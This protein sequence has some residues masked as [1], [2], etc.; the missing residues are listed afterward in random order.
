M[1]PFPVELVI[2][3]AWAAVALTV[4]F[5]IGAILGYILSPEYEEQKPG[6]NGLLFLLGCVLSFAALYFSFA[7]KLCLAASVI[8]LAL[9][10]FGVVAGRIER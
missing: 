9:A 10:V 7:A 8:V 4:A 3:V 1:M 2:G 5:L 6:R